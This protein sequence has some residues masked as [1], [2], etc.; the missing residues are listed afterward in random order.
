MVAHV[1]KSHSGRPLPGNLRQ[2]PT[3]AVGP[4]NRLADRE[5]EFD[6][7]GSRFRRVGAV[8]QVELGLQAQITADR[9]GGRLLHRIRP[10][11]YL[12]KCRDG[13][14]A[15]EDGGNHRTRGDEL[16]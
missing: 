3:P 1:S 15:L 11:G 4:G 16:Q 7:S 2:Y 6:F 9:A 13:A 12:A 8:Y 5:P 14:G 10:T